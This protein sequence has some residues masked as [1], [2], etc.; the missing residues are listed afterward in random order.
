MK[1]WIDGAIYPCKPIG[2]YPQI[3]VERTIHSKYKGIIISFFEVRGET[4]Q[5]V[6][7]TNRMARLLVKRI[8]MALEVK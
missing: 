7:M 3:Y 2:K 8:N 5:L 6:S 1:K 4:G